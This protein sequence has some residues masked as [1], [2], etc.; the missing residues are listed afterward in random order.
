MRVRRKPES[1]YSFR[2]SCSEII[3]S[4]AIGGGTSV[5]AAAFCP[6]I[7]AVRFLAELNESVMLAAKRRLGN[8]SY[9]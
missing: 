4:M 6:F 8:R 5:A 7:I 2:N 3:Y 1:L 9:Q